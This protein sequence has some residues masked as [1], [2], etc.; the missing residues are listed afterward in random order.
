MH[1]AVISMY[2]TPWV[3][4]KTK[5]AGWGLPSAT[6]Q[7]MSPVKKNEWTMLKTAKFRTLRTRRIIAFPG[8]GARSVVSSSR[9]PVIRSAG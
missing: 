6:T 1:A 7:T 9:S 2:M 8:A 4:P 3:N 5:V